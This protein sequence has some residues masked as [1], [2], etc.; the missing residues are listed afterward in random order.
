MDINTPLWTHLPH[1]LK[2]IFHNLKT[3]DLLSARAVCTLWRDYLNNKV[4]WTN[5]QLKLDEDNIKR[6]SSMNLPGYINSIRIHTSGL[7]Q[8][9]IQELWD[10]TKKRSIDRTCIEGGKM[11]TIR[12]VILYER[13]IFTPDEF[14]GIIGLHSKILRISNN[15]PTQMKCILNTIHLMKCLESTC[16]QE[17]H[18]LEILEIR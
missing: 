12:Q 4:Y 7:D 5:S 17:R 14:L 8:S 2:G 18:H 3:S 13:K 1:I 11:R 10:W 16:D 9:M 6:I 15:T